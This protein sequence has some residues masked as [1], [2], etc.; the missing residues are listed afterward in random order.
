MSNSKWWLS[1]LLAPALYFV[2]VGT[3][4]DGFTGQPGLV[5]ARDPS[6]FARLLA[7]VGGASAARDGVLVDLGFMAL[8]A[9]ALG[10]CLAKAS[11]PWVLVLPALG[12]DFLEGTVLWVIAGDQDPSSA[13]L[14]A[15]LA[16]AVAK[17][18]A[19][20]AAVVLLVRAQFTD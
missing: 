12:L 9:G 2:L 7:D 19:Y 14:A 17:L 4:F 10:L 20:A 18:L 11:G 6:T 8:L 13:G 5:F 15:L 1:T 3:R 16:L